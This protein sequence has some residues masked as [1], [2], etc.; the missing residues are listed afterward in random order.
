VLIRR[1]EDLLGW[2]LALAGAAYALAIVVHGSGVDEA[3]PLVGCGLLLC[4]ELAT[5]SLDARWRVAAEPGLVMSR[6]LALA[7]MALAGLAAAALV[8]ALAA[9]SLGGGLAWT[10]L[11]CAA[12]VLVVALAARLAARA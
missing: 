8:L 5:W 7:G 11:G 9:T 1:V 6:A 12:A 2:S 4:G 3:A 10:M